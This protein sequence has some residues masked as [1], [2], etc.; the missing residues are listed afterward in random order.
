MPETLLRNADA[1]LFDA[2]G[3]RRPQL[4]VLPG[5]EQPRLRNGWLWK[6]GCGGRWKGE[7]QLHYQPAD[8]ADHRPII[9]AAL[10][11]FGSPGAGHGA[12]AKFIPVAKKAN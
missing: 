12:A 5:D 4:Q 1:A 9:A 2:K 6:T 10:I 11:H 8:R 7:F 3:I